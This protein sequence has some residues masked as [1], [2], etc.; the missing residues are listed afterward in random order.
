MNKEKKRGDDEPI[1]EIPLAQLVPSTTNQRKNFR[2]LEELTASIKDKGVL[3]PLLVREIKSETKGENRFE[4]IAGERRYRGAT[5]AGLETAPCRVLTLSDE[6]ALEVQMIENLQRKDLHPLEEAEGF[7]HMREVLGIEERDIAQRVAK[8]V[9]YVTHRLALTN[10]IKEAKTDFLKDLITLAHALEICRLAPEV[11]TLALA[12]C[13]ESKNVL[14]EESQQWILV[15]DKERP[16]VHVRYLQSW[17]VRNVHLNLRSAPFKTDDARLREDGLT[18]VECPQRTGCNT[19]LFADIKDADTCLNP[20]CFKSKVQTLVQITKAEI[21]AKRDTPAAFITPYYSTRAEGVLTRYEYEVIE[22]KADRCDYAEQAI[23]AEGDKSG[24]A[25]WICREK[26]CKDH[27]G[28]AGSINVTTLSSGSSSAQNPMA[29]KERKQELFDL[30]VDDIVRKRVFAEALKTYSFPLDRE[31]LN[32][33][34]SEFFRR[35]TSYDQRTIFAV[36]GKDETASS[37]MR[38]NESKML[39]EIKKMEENELVQFMMLCTFAHFGANQYMNR[40][41]DQS[42]VEKLSRER[43]VNHKLIDA[44]VRLELTPKKYKERHQLYLNKIEEGKSAKK[45]LVYDAPPKASVSVK[46][47]SEQPQEGAEQKAAA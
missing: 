34:A 2:G 31:Q 16:A 43:G 13:Y 4:I 27:L 44:Q 20:S 39:A 3:E 33:V 6:E 38:G 18:C 1:R 41:A 15:P 11:Q 26:S 45:P 23:V 24:R 37:T 8:K 10:L 29:G 35:I 14:D 25:V 17:L 40:K 19:A 30:R 32:V 28:R 46:D 21:D 36:L 22:R 9:S 47:A 42:A 7:K 5:R 12:A